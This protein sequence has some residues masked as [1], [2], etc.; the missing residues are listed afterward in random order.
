MLG[1]SAQIDSG[2]ESGRKGFREGSTW[3][4][5]QP[6]NELESEPAPLEVLPPQRVKV[7]REPRDLGRGQLHSRHR[8]LRAG[9]HVVV[10]LLGVKRQ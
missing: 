4:P 9:G 5:L 3:A 7:H 2:L 10:E 1:L 6:K 8:R